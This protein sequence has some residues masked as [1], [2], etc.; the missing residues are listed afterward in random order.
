[1]QMPMSAAAVYGVSPSPQPTG[2][3]YVD[4]APGTPEPMARTVAHG[5]GP[6]ASPTVALVAIIGL[7]IALIAS[8]RVEVSV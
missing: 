4:H 8:V 1:M 6:L 5:S 2:T 3:P 7:A